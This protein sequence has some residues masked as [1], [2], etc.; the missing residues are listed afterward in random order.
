MHWQHSY[1]TFGI[2]AILQH[3]TL[4][5]SPAAHTQIGWM[6][7]KVVATEE[8]VANLTA[9]CFCPA[10]LTSSRAAAITGGLAATATDRV[11]NVHSNARRGGDAQ[12]NARR[13]RAAAPRAV[14][15]VV[16]N[17]GLGQTTRI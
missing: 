17:S 1:L 5:A 9:A 15:P 7:D 16:S 13:H 3:Y 12:R 8:I 10:P 11:G 14:P 2:A 6:A 4:S